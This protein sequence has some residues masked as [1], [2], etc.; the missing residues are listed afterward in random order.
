MHLIQTYSNRFGVR[1]FFSHIEWELWPTFSDMLT[2][3]EL[4]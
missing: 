4:F 3:E 2:N 1:C